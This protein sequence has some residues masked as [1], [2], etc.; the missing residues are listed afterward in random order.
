MKNIGKRIQSRRGFTLAETLMAILILLMVTAVVAAGI[1]AASNALNKAVEASHA[2]VLL[3]TTMTALRDEL[4]TA[5]E[6]TVDGKTVTYQ[7]GSGISSEITVKADG[8]YLKKQL[9]DGTAIERLLVSQKA[10]TSDLRADYSGVS[11]AGNIVSF[12]GLVVQKGQSAS[13]AT[14]ADLDAFKIRAVG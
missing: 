6:I 2:Q 8:I 14:L 3:S 12:S 5:K 1:P 10:A 13:A 4:T 7:D 9:E 11:I